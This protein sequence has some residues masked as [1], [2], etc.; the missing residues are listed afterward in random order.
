[1]EDKTGTMKKYQIIY[2]DPPW[3]FDYYSRDWHKKALQS[4]SVYKHYDDMPLEAIKKLPIQ[5]FEDNDCVLFLWAVSLLLPQALEVM[6][7]WGFEYKGIAFTW[8][9]KNKKSDS[10]FWGMGR[11]TRNNPEFCLLGKRGNPKRISASVH[12]VVEEK[13]QD[14][15][16]K[17]IEVRERIVALMGDIPRIELFAREKSDGWDAY[18]NQIESDIE[19]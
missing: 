13:I 10:L 5:Q 16:K 7:E 12:S 19:L 17:P 9:K 4:R 15:S 1:M 2:A 6:K 8:I 3:Q 18:G 11:W 14:H